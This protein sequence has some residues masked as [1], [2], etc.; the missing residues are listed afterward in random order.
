MILPELPAEAAPLLL[1]LQPAFTQPTWHRFLLLLAAA[2]L[3]TGR[4]TVAN[5]LRTLGRLACGHRSSYQ[6][7]LSAASWPGARLA[8]LL[9]GFVLRHLAPAGR[10]TLVGDD[11]V[12]SHPGRKVYGKA[13]HRD[14]VRSSHAYT[15]WRYGHKWV[16]LAVLVRFP[17]AK[18]PWALPVLVDLYRSEQDNRARRRPHR[19][20]AQLM[21]RL[22][23]LLLLRFP[24]RRFLFVGDSGYGSHE[25]ARFVYRHRDRLALVSK[26]H[27]DANLFE[28]PPPYRGKGRPRVK[29]AAL[30]KP[31][32]AVAQRRRLRRT[33]VGW[34]GGGSRQ[35]GLARGEGHWYKAGAGLVPL[36]WVFVRDQS[37]THRDEYFFT[38]DLTLTPEAI[39]SHYAGRW[40]I[41]CTFEELR[42]HLGLE[43]TRGWCR[44]T[45][46]RAA[47][48]LFGP[49]T[50]VALLYN[51]LPAEKRVGTVSWPGKQTTTFSD[52][53]TAVR[54]WL[55]AEW[56]FPQAEADTAAEKLPPPLRE[57]IFSA[58]APAA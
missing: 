12:E 5:L 27:P 47:P 19:T 3:T 43:T 8:C 20:P 56:V 18:R 24:D 34:Y 58:L 51:A 10:V 16:V 57:I 32:E 9:T 55:W 39:I 46:L 42:A 22:L 7:V 11:T 21:C 40:S 45:V 44:Q 15:A 41:E 35:V 25:V 36:R 31:R 4:R 2:V 50:V 1:A 17:F 54:R 37:G 53:L 52:A 23:R 49:Y 33:A 30:P 26:L 29:G 6:R 14:P 48:C 38:T 28:P 13:R